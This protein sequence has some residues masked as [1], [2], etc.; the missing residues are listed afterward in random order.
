MAETESYGTEK[1]ASLFPLLGSLSLSRIVS[2]EHVRER[3][4]IRDINGDWNEER[5]RDR[6]VAQRNKNGERREE[7]QV[8][9]KWEN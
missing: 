1:K 2:D 8:K 4:E 9:V 7:A 6:E 3:N 5:D